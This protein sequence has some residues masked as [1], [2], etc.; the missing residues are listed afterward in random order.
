[1]FTIDAPNRPNVSSHDSLQKPFGSIQDQT[2]FE[3]ARNK[4]PD[5]ATHKIKTLGHIGVCAVDDITKWRTER[6][7]MA[8]DESCTASFK[9]LFR[10]CA[11]AKSHRPGETI[12][13]RA[14]PFLQMALVRL[15][16]Y[17]T[18]INTIHS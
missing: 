6:R 7:I 17:K 15:R 1:M 5:W 11:D 16:R 10:H 12:E 13:R 18:K 2:I 3:A 8:Q 9:R 14:A 4:P